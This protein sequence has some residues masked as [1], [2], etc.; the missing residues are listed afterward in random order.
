MNFSD[1]ERVAAFIENNNLKLTK[2]I[3]QSDLVIFNTCGVR[4]TAEDR[5]Y[6]Q[7]HNL[8]K[9]NQDTFIIVTGCVAHRKDVQRKLKN[10]ADLFISINKLF[11]LNF[12]TIHNTKYSIHNT[13]KLK[14]NNCDYLK[15]MPKYKSKRKVLV[16]IMIGCNNFCSYCVVPYVRGREKSRP[17]HEVFHELEKAVKNGCK[18]V[19]LLGQNVNSYEFRIGNLELGIESQNSKFKIQNSQKTITFPILL[20]HLATAFPSIKFHFLTSHPKDFS[21]ELIEVII[22]HDNTPNKIHLPIQSGSN[23]VL[24]NMNRPYTQKHYLSLIKKI[25]TRIPNVK[26]TTDV[27]VGFP[28]ETEK[29]FQE[30]VKVFKKVKFADAYINKYSPRPETAA[31]KLGDPISW[32]EK[33][34]REKILRNLL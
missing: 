34:R 1:S 32:E 22:K 18:V 14:G 7:I 11:N 8:R 33:K 20:D 12:K 19:L 2:N 29:E 9:K 24:K 4:Q 5:V 13:K 31:E 17:P 28:T 30:T 26:I 27:I 15:I 25:R 21:D 3:N 16:P 6:G 23:K 10:K